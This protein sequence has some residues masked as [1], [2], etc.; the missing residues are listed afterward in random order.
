MGYNLN[1]WSAGWHQILNGLKL[2]I[3][4]H[5]FIPEALELLSSFLSLNLVN[6]RADAGLPGSCYKDLLNVSSAWGNSRWLSTQLRSK[7]R[8]DGVQ[9]ICHITTAYGQWW[10]HKFSKTLRYKTAYK[11]TSHIITFKIFFRKT[12]NYM[13]PTVMENLE[14]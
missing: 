14:K 9:S 12:W 1:S 8:G 2:V 6:L 5:L 3:S 13:I 11:V 10:L 4:P 7:E